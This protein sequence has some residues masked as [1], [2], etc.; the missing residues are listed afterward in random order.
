MVPET[1]KSDPESIRITFSLYPEDVVV[2]NRALA[3]GDHFGVRLDISKVIRLMIRCSNIEEIHENFY[4]EI[5]REV[6]G[7]RSKRRVGQ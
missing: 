2:I 4:H 1:T 5:K 6:S 7:K 3:R